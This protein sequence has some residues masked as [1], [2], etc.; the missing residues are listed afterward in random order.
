M[1]ETE[2]RQ[3]LEKMFD[4]GEKIIEGANGLIDIFRED[5]P[6]ADMVRIEEVLPMLKVTIDQSEKMMKARRSHLLPVGWRAQHAEMVRCLKRLKE[7][8]E[9]CRRERGRN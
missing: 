2:I 4:G 9:Q 3:G 6:R 1:T 7:I 8:T 5:G